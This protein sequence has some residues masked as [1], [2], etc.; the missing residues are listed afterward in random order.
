MTESAEL[1]GRQLRNNQK[2]GNSAGLYLS[3]GH[4]TVKVSGSILL[5]DWSRCA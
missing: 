3:G 5:V 4:T 1:A 2:P